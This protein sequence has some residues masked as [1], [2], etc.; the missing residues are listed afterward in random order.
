MRWIWL[1]STTTTTATAEEEET[2]ANSFHFATGWK[3]S[4]S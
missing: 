1:I 3:R 4:S 2:L